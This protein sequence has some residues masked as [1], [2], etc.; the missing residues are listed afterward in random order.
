[1]KRFECPSCGATGDDIEVYVYQELPTRIWCSKCLT[2]ST[3]GK[4]KVAFT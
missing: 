3:L 4:E 1:M 2:L